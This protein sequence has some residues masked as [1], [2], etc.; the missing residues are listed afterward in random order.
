MCTI[1]R[2]SNIINTIPN[3]KTLKIFLLKSF[4]IFKISAS[5]FG[6][7]SMRRQFRA[8]T[9]EFL[10]TATKGVVHGV[11][12]VVIQSSFGVTR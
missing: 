5:E 1:V 8:C 9:Y 4:E 7:M 11:H 2:Q 10:T 3:Y 6:T 12:K